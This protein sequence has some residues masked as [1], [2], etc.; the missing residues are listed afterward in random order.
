MSGSQQFD[1]CPYGC[2]DGR[3]EEDGLEI[4]PLDGE[5]LAHHVQAADTGLGHGGLVGED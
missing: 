3:G 1:C 2:E 5:V 4:V